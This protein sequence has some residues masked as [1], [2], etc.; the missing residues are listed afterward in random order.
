MSKKTVTT[1]FRLDPR[2]FEEIAGSSVSKKQL[3]DEVEY[4]VNQKIL[5]MIDRGISPIKGEKAF[6]AYKDPKK[7]PGKLKAANRP[8]L[9]LTGKML[10]YYEAQESKG[11]DLSVTIGIHKD[12]P[13]DVR[14]RADANQFGTESATSRSAR[15]RFKE[16]RKFKLSKSARKKLREAASR[17]RKGIAARPFIPRFQQ[18]FTPSIM[19]AIRSAFATVLSKALKRRK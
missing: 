5:P 13:D 16:S 2:L 7:Y 12:A 3:R 10:S 19:V 6:T 8:N 18:Q 9:T 11:G 4:V 14:V 1:T 15:E 17:L